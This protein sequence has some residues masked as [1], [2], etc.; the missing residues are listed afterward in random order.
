DF[1]GAR[2]LC[3]TVLSATTV[4]P[5]VQPRTIARVAQGYAELERDNYGRAI[6]CF[7]EVRDPG[8]T[9]KFFLHWFWRL[10]AQLGLSEVWLQ[11]GDL[12]NARS[13]ADSYLQ[14]ALSTADPYVQALAWELQA[15]VAMA[16]HN[17]ARAEEAIEKALAVLDNF[18]LPI[19]AWRVHAT[20]WDFHR[21][22]INKEAADRHLERAVSYVM[23][24]ADSFPA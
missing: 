15:R 12:V 13:T 11:S 24:I 3:D 14:S 7:N 18:E 17:R 2:R 19:A 8:R 10:C 22:A 9:S 20:A 6:E 23:Q 4:Y 1:E 16:E 5:T 21:N